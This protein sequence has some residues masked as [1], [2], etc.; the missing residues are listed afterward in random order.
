VPPREQP[1]REREP[2]ER[3]DRHTSSSIRGLSLKVQEAELKQRP[4]IVVSTPGR[5]IDHV[6]NTPQ[7]A[8]REGEGTLGEVGQTHLFEHPVCLVEHEHL[9]AEL[10]GSHFHFPQA[11]CP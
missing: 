6:R 10:T 2:S 7:R 11:V 1:G 5:L 3:S 9:D 8:A 4:D